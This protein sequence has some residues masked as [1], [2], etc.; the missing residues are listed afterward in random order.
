[1]LTVKTKLK[2]VPKKGIG[3]IANQEIKKG[4]IVWKYHPLI[5][6][7]I[8]KKDIPKEAKDFFK[9]YGVDHGKDYFILNTD[10]ARFTN[11]SKKPNIK[12]VGLFGH[13]IALRDIHKGEEIT[14]DY[15]TFDVNGDNF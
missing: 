10:N 15:N 9:I 7:K 12:N 8:M 11:H 1:M 13:N 2:E 3:L 4:Q 5:D 6:I 14:I